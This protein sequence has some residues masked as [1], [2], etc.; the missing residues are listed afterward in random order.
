MGQ[1]DAI[2]CE[3]ELFCQFDRLTGPRTVPAADLIHLKNVV[4]STAAAIGPHLSDIRLTFPQYTDHGIQHLC[5][6]A[7][8]IHR[9]LPKQPDGGLWLNAVELSCL[10]LGILLHD[11]GMYVTPAEKQATLNSPEYQSYAARDRDRAAA[12]SKARAD[13]KELTARAIED[14]QL[15]EYYRRLHPDRVQH[16]LD[17]HADL[18]T[19]L[20]YK[21]VR[22]AGEVV[23]L[24]ESHGWGVRE[25]N[26][27]RDGDRCVAKLPTNRRIDNMRVNLQY[28]ACCLRLGDIVDFDQSRTP[29][30]VYE[31]IDFT[32]EQ[33]VLEWNK[34]LS[35]SGWDVD[36]HRVMYDV[37]CTKPSYYVAVNEF[38]DWVDHELRECRYLLD[39]AP[40]GD[41][42]AYALRLAHIVDRREV[43]MADPRYVAGG[44]RFQLE[45]DEI[46]R[47][48]MDKS[49]YPD[50]TLFLRELLQNS[51][52]AC[53]YQKA[54]ADEA[55]MGDKYIPRIEVWDHSDD[56]TDRRVVFQDNGIGMSQRQV[57]NYF[58]RVGKS[59]YKSPE[60]EMERQRLAGRG[61][62]LDACSQFGIGFLSCFLGGDKI[63]VETRRHDCDTLRV[64]ITGPG[65][66]FLIER[67]AGQQ[68]A[69]PFLSPA[70]P[71]ADGPALHAGTRVTVHL[72]QAPKS[73]IGWVAHTISRFAANQDIPI[74]VLSGRR[75]TPKNIPVGR[76]DRLAKPEPEVAHGSWVRPC[77]APSLVRLDRHCD[78]LRGSAAVWLLER[79]GVPWPTAGDIVARGDGRYC[80]APAV[81]LWAQTARGRPD[82]GPECGH[83]LLRI[84]IDQVPAAE[85]ATGLGDEVSQAQR[86]LLCSAEKTEGP[87]RLWLAEATAEY[88]RDPD[89][90][91]R[92]G[93]DPQR[94][95]V[96][97]LRDGDREAILSACRACGVP[98]FEAA[99][100]SSRF[101]CA[102]HGIRIPSGV[103][104][105]D[106]AGLSTPAAGSL[107]NGVTAYV[108][109][110]GPSAP[111][112]SSNRLFV[113]YDQ[114]HQLRFEAGK[115]VVRHVSALARQ[116]A[117]DPA[118][119]SWAECLVNDLK[120]TAPAAFAEL[121]AIEPWIRMDCMVGGVYRRLDIKSFCETFGATAAKGGKA[122]TRILS[123]HWLLGCLPR[124]RDRSGASV[125]DLQPLRE[126]LTQ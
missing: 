97:A 72:R 77:L 47:L 109:A 68:H 84:L 11:I 78:W 96:A 26:D 80:V 93:V 125:V 55:G 32:E 75:R 112:P 28:L 85:V 61:I 48:L 38:L 104:E 108:D 51:L 106:A 120:A 43:R 65:K 123:D 6:V 53:R 57:E 42:E 101:E 31:D 117:G 113:P 69:V 30:A 76:W 29:L 50:D 46:L 36:E 122:D 115:A 126:R 98:T 79:N 20:Q 121:A 105:W 107:P 92:A 54:L 13:G 83:A 23:R 116:H 18:A 74:I 110:V 89:S 56:P 41:E 70:D 4:L 100:L 63:E 88:V 67:A 35:V 49:L 15:A 103:L 16:Y 124:R 7:D 119:D 91:R 102:L 81:R 52:D 62:H 44:F 99:R 94:P 59:F 19:T 9:F 1:Y 2:I 21:Q 37:P 82:G 40:R 73:R 60:F 3:T 12:A 95:M 39:A 64:T 22:F 27:P 118:W 58:L 87:D 71:A 45:Y 17:A 14:A 66:F 5:N 86:A 8:K 111:K 33:S 34:H 25:S 90:W 24:C 114:S 10:W